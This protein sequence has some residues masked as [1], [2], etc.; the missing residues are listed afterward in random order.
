VSDERVGFVPAEL[1]PGGEIEFLLPSGRMIALP[2]CR[3][4]F[5]RWQGPVTDDHGSS[6]VVDHGGRPASPAIAVLRAFQGAGWEGAWIDPIGHT[7][8][9]DDRSAPPLLE[10]PAGP[11][12]VLHQI[13]E[14]ARSRKG[15]WDLLCWREGHVLFA[16]VLRLGRDR[17]R[18]HQLSWLESALM[19]GRLTP[20]SFLVVEWSQL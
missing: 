10:L 15:T 12:Q 14:A 17:I 3:P 1:N 20:E 7:L 2:R 5:A 19:K 13:E 9:T 11:G 16:V 6:D 8:R 18:S 4:R